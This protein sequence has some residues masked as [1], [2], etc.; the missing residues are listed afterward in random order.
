MDQVVGAQLPDVLAGI[1]VAIRQVHRG[2]AR[3]QFIDCRTR[4]ARCNAAGVRRIVPEQVAVEAIAYLGNRHAIEQRSRPQLF[5]N[6]VIRERPD[7]P[8]GARR[9]PH[10]IRS[11]NGIQAPLP[12]LDRPTVQRG[13]LH[14]QTLRSTRRCYC[15]RRSWSA[16]SAGTTTPASRR[17]EE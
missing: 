16:A 7:V 14:C 2:D 4:V 8:L 11:G 15:D 17:D 1:L 13:E 12:G 5:A 10:P 6:D 9:R 3:Q